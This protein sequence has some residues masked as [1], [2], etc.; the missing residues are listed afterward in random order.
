MTRQAGAPIAPDTALHL[1]P[2]DRVV[3]AVLLVAVTGLAWA[4]LW[5][6]AAVMA[7]MD[8]AMMRD[9]AMTMNEMP[10]SWS[11]V[12]AALVFAMWTVMMAAMMV[13]A[14]SP[15]VA[16][17]AA[18]NRRRRERAAP[19]VPTAVFLAG[20]LAAWS[21]FAALATAAQYVLQRAGLVTTMMESA[22]LP[23]SA[24]LFIAAGLYQLTPLKDVCLARCRSPQV[25][26]LTEWRDGIVG[27][28]VMG[29]RHG[30]FC[31]GCCAGLM[32]LLFAVAVMDLRWVAALTILVT[33]EKLLPAPRVVRMAIGVAL[34]AVGLGFAVAG[35]RG[36]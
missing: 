34:I 9:M 32:V 27:G 3:V 24:A 18:I 23:L 12:D 16:A 8:A 7:E 13:P 1:T 6:Q 25:F 20:Y 2:R 36:V 14:A 33:A 10:A 21:A 30:L 17:F 11:A 31:T 22:S 28:L 29:L 35:W 5:H 15:M 4:F 19:A 26:V